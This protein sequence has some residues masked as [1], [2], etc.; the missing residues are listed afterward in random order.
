MKTLC[1]HVAH[2]YIYISFSRNLCALFESTR[3]L[4]FEKYFY[5]FVYVTGIWHRSQC[6]QCVHTKQHVSA[7]QRYQQL[8]LADPVNLQYC[9][10]S[11]GPTPEE[12]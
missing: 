1:T 3:L 11:T 12:T 4:E 5:G 7:E 8:R 6:L 10:V 9:G 2:K